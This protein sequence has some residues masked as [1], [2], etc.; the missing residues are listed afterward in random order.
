MKFCTY[1]S[2][3]FPILTEWAA[4][5]FANFDARQPRHA[6]PAGALRSVTK[7]LLWRNLFDTVRQRRVPNHK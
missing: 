2:C 6:I 4:G 5:P 1:A 7:P 3:L